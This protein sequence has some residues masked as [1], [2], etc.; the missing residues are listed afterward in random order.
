MRQCDRGINTEFTAGVWV[1]GTRGFQGVYARTVTQ[2]TPARRAGIREENSLTG[3]RDVI[4]EVNGEPVESSDQ[5]LAAI[6]RLPF[7][8]I[9]K[10]SIRRRKPGGEIQAIPIEVKLAKRFTSPQR[11]FYSQVPKYQWRGLSVD[12]YTAIDE[13]AA[14]SRLVDPQGCVAII[15]VAND[16]AAWKAG[17]RPGMFLTKIGDRRVKDESEFREATQAASGPV[18]VSTTARADAARLETQTFELPP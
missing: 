8:S 3:E 17:L 14:R 12:Y 4:A 1:F 2:Y 18:K 6:G 5:F 7:E 10:L 16:S 11:P 13:F 15:S 9:V